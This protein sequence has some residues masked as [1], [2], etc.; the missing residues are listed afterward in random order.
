MRIPLLP[1]RLRSWLGR[2]D[3]TATIEFVLFFPVM[4]FL[5]LSSIELGMFLMR[6]VLLDRAVDINVRAL[7]LG[8]L[9]PM[10]SD[11]LKSRICDDAL[12][13]NDCQSSIAIEL[14]PVSTSTWEFP[15]AEY[16][17]V[18]RDSEID[19][20][21]DFTPGTQNELMLVRVCVVVDPFFGTTPYVMDLPLDA[22][23]GYN[24]AAISTFVNEP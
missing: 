11:E 10:T 3:G 22:S 19:P 23:G 7:R 12:I 14:V 15:Q 20:V 4:M 1:R 5:F 24:I 17:C 9:D 18:D 13:L 6:T 21:V 16:T 2:E 8:T